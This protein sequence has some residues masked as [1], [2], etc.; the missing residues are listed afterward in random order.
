MDSLDESSPD[1]VEK[2]TW[3]DCSFTFDKN[4]GIITVKEGALA[5]EFP[6]S[7]DKSEIRKIK[8]ESGV[9]A[10]EDSSYLFADLSNLEE[11]EGGLDVS[12]T[13]NMEDMFYGDINLKSLDFSDWD[14]SNISNML[15]MLSGTNSLQTIIMGA[16]SIF[17]SDTG[18][19]MI[20][21]PLKNIPDA[22]F[23]S[24][25]KVLKLYMKIAM[26]L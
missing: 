20:E 17:N 26:S 18:L 11:I 23:V 5:Q 6:I 10:P 24:N 21:H 4:T 2:E 1:A 19:P 22:G 3:G 13:W 7:L 16:T 12:N 14:T 9:K 8:L 15:N 25:Q